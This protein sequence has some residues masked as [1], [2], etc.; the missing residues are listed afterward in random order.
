MSVLKDVKIIHTD[1]SLHIGRTY[2]GNRRT[3]EFKMYGENEF[4][5]EAEEV[6]NKGDI[7]RRIPGTFMD[8][9]CAKAMR[10]FLDDFLEGRWQE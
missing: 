7:V 4:V 6:G 5:F 2:S 3:F 9:A 10:S 8:K 1:V